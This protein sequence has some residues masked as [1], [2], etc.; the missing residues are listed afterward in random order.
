[1]RN[2]TMVGTALMIALV[3]FGS[4]LAAQRSCTGPNGCSMSFG[5][6]ATIVGTHVP[7]GARMAVRPDPSSSRLEV[8]TVANTGWVL[9]IGRVGG[10]NDHPVDR[11]QRGGSAVA[12]I[13]Q[14]GTQVVVAT[15]AAS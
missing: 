4:P 6:G 10:G 1:M 11:S 7:S 2:G 15:L 8:V 13:P 5:V 14:D 12:P 9:S 3:A